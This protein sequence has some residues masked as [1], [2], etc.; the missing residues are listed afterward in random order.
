[1]LFSG[2]ARLF[3]AS[4]C[5]FVL[6]V[7]VPVSAAQA[8]TFTVNRTDDTPDAA[9]GG[10]CDVDLG[11]TGDQCTLRAAIQAANN[12]GAGPHTI[13]LPAGT[14]T[15]T[16]AGSDN[17]A[18]NGDLDILTSVT[19]TGAG[20]A[21]TIVQASPTSAATAVDR[22][23]EVRSFAALS[24]SGVT[25]RHGQQFGGSGGGISNFGGT[26]VLDR[27]V[28][29]DNAADS[30]GGI[31]VQGPTTVTN[32]TIDG[33][34]A[35][36]GI[37][38]G[39]GSGGPNAR[40]DQRYPERQ[41]GSLRYCLSNRRWRSVSLFGRDRNI[42]QRHRH[43]QQRPCRRWDRQGPVVAPEYADP[44]QHDRRRQYRRQLQRHDHL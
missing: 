23:F 6:L 32:S 5:S 16:R 8:A 43:R 36:A 25:V 40:H 37:G 7:L 34:T 14:Y 39:R 1:V 29:T 33:N 20:A 10:A 11:T 17:T 22:V 15:L 9:V 24:L 30:A 13:T 27:V 2:S 26:L 38:G 44:A 12:S 4:L 35:S 3:L 41:L 21:T 28:I 31:R 19:I 42:D 18:L